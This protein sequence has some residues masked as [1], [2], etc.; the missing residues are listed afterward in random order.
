MTS[1][2]HF[3]IKADSESVDSPNYEQNQRCTVDAG[4]VEV[5]ITI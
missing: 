4:E 1:I 2:H 5:H 3:N